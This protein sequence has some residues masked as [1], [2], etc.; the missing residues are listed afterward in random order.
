MQRPE[1]ARLDAAGLVLAGLVNSIL[2]PADYGL[3]FKPGALGGGRS[4]GER[5]HWIAGHHAR[6]QGGWSFWFV[7][8]TSF[9]WSY[10][11][12]GRRLRREPA[13]PALAIGVALLAAAVDL[14]GVV[15][16]I[17]VLPALADRGD[18]ETFRA[19]QLLAH[20]LTDIAAFGLYTAAGLLLLPALRGTP[21]V[22]R[23]LL[24]L[25][26]AEWGIS[27]VATALLAFD[28]AGGRTVAGLGLAL[29][30]PWVWLG[31]WW[32]L[33]GPRPGPG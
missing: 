10:F 31:A 21:G 17:A 27:A 1:G 20:A 33:K 23:A 18:T 7:V 15:A 26:A 13:W 3:V 12:L 22:P 32:V 25:G 4:L 14:V 5:V 30:A 6:W 16:N 24:L 19:V 11:A 9:A 28:V 2:A 8:T 29:Y